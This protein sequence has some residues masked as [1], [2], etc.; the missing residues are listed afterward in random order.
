MDQPQRERIRD[1][2][3]GLVKGEILFDDLSRV[4]YSTDASIFQVQPLGAVVP[5]DE[6][7]VCALL[8]YAGENRIPLIARG[9]GS[10]VAGE[11]LGPGL[12]VD[13]SRHF[14]A[15]LDVGADSVRVQ[16]GVV[17]R[18]LNVCLAREGRRFAPDPA[19][20][21]QCTIGGMLATNAS[22][23]RALRHG[24]TRD[25]VVSLRA[26][27][28]NGDAVSA[29]RHPRLPS[30][31]VP[32]G[33]LEEIVSSVAT[34]IEQHAA[35]VRDCRP[36]TPFNR[37]GYLLHDVLRDGELDLARLL[38]GS[39]GTLAVFTEAT[40]RTIPLP[41]GRA[42]VLLAFPR[43]DAALRASLLAL[44]SR[45]VACELIDR[46]LLILVRGGDA[47][48]AALVPATAEAAL[49]IEYEDD[50][51]AAAHATA[52]ELADRLYRVER[53]AMQALVAVSEADVER[54]W[55]LR[56][57]VLPSLYGLRGGS[58]A[59]AYVEDV[60]VPPESLPAYLHRVQEIL[61]RHETTAS[62]LV[63]A[64]TG[65]VHARP[66]LDL[67]RPDNVARLQA[68]AE[69][70]YALTLQLGGTISAQHG[71]GIARTPW[72]ARQYGPLYPIFRELKAI[73]DPRHILNP[74]KIV[75]PDPS[76]PAWP[77][78]Q[79]PVPVPVPVPSSFIGHGH[80]HGH[81]TEG[82]APAL[83]W[84]VADMRAECANCNGC[85]NCRTEEPSR[86]MCPI[87]RATHE[88]AATPRAKANLMR[89][90][91]ADGANGPALSSDEVRAVA[92][93][94]VNCKMCAIECPAH[95]D[96]PRLMLE[97]KA[98]NVARHGMHRH[99]WVLARTESFARAGSAVAPLVNFALGSRTARWLLEKLFGLSR[100]R[101][102]PTFARRSFLRRAERRGWTRKPHP[103]RP[104][105]AYFV[106]VFANYNDPLIAESVVAVLQHNGI[107]V[108]VP[109]GQRGCGM[110]PLAYG[111]VEAAREAV[112]H[113]LRLFADLAREDM[114]ILCAEPTA[115]LM[116]RH[117]ALDLIDDP[118][119][120]LVAERTVEFTSF[121]WDLYE[122]GQ[123]RTDFRRL[124]LALGHHVPCHLKA[125]GR[126]PAGARLLS[127][128]PGVRVHTIDVGCS[129]MAG[130]FGL[131]AEHYAV[132]LEAGRAMLD[133]LR[134]PRVLHG[135]TE[136][137]PCR[138]QMEDGGG[139]RTLH[140]AQYL[141]LAYG[142]V[143]EIARRLHE[144][145]RQL[146]LR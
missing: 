78:R 71:T 47:E 25:H 115:A 33:R 97:A 1:D 100:G 114:P 102:L 3:K 49:L 54:F 137:S 136:C 7:D 113:N 27:L 52:A 55:R 89:H 62:F 99:D 23:A 67:S 19:S 134:R 50:S 126:P 77:L 106:D 22:G 51:P 34:L 128:I 4:L 17:C 36:K 16:P 46:R 21:A 104:R 9:A 81:G 40:L 44:P 124:E 101:R 91:L 105:V 68:I 117:D 38:V 125:L 129:G 118:D 30:P 58:Q 146:V 93:L 57:S 94:C 95:V 24:Y 86:R 139:K 79:P 120:R 73:F 6:D 75:G 110:A 56:E 18:D 37:C 138:M 12:V 63:H 32:P 109:P 48:A 140:P 59:V 144:P 2:L 10:G 20:G 15:I 133:E 88:E 80:G 119:A 14:R 103:S 65:Q 61:Q 72:V 69:E 122:R 107:E 131:K 145:I 41:Q 53:L 96:V 90:L 26:V 28:D 11:S 64:L 141:A 60:G 92:D 70:V 142:L 82:R 29:A 132:S 143:P 130:T 31:A 116:L 5:R 111:D 135:S 121:L 39:E 87:F 13:L 112:G 66:F 43:L 76:F 84:T 45:P 42:V 74:G 127:L 85:G 108:Y 123:L 8:R 83:R 98:A 35:A